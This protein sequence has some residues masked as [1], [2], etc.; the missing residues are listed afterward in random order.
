M[1]VNDN[2]MIQLVWQVVASVMPEGLF[3]SQVN[4]QVNIKLSLPIMQYYYMFRGKCGNHFP[5][6]SSYL[7]FHSLEV[8]SHY[9]DPQLQVAENFI[10]V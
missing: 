4:M 1:K 2:S 3:N 5:A 7:N 9:R 6:K 10:F 8:V